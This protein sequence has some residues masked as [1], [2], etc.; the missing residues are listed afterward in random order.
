MPRRNWKGYTNCRIYGSADTMDWIGDA[1]S[2][3][4]NIVAAPSGLEAARYLKRKFG[5]DYVVEN[6]LGMQFVQELPE[7]DWQGRRVLVVDQQVSA[8]SIRQALEARGAKVT[9]ASWFMMD[10]SLRQ[11][12]DIRLTEEDQFTET[13]ESGAF[14][15]LIGDPVLQRMARHFQGEFIAKNQFSL[16][17]KQN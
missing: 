4:K 3:A 5:T 9:V 7:K 15:V 16:S 10:T 2:A 11:D 17:G 6:P 13:A 1:G 12:G 14:D 8:E